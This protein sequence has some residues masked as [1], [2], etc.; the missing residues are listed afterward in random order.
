[1]VARVLAEF[2]V[3]QPVVT[4]ERA[5]EAIIIEGTAAPVRGRAK[6]MD[7]V[8]RYKKKY[9][10]DMNPEA[11]GYFIVTP[12]TAFAFTEHGDEFGKTATRYEFQ[13]RRGAASR[14]RQ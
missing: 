2:L 14:R 4:T 12:H 9:D 11:D 8:R 1:M 13:A 10:W 3:D 7:F 5:D 6:L